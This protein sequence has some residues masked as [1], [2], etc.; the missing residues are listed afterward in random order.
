M[1]LELSR[2]HRTPQVILRHLKLARR[3]VRLT[4]QQQQPRVRLQCMCIW[5][6]HGV[7][8]KL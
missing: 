4:T 2:P 5:N 6:A 7:K 8:H 1:V 3:R